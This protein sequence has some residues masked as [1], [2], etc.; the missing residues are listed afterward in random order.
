MCT[1]SVPIRPQFGL[2]VSRK[3][4]LHIGLDKCGSTSIQ[5]FLWMNREQL[6]KA[7]FAVPSLLNWPSHPWLGVLAYQERRDCPVTARMS[8]QLDLEFASD[9]EW[10]GMLRTIHEEFIHW[11]RDQ[12]DGTLLLSAED[13]IARLDESE[14]ANLGGLLRDEVDDI[15]ILVYVR[16]PVSFAVSGWSQRVKSGDTRGML[17]EDSIGGWSRRI[18]AIKYWEKAFPGRVEVRLFDPRAFFAADLV[19]DYR[20]SAGIPRDLQLP[21]PPRTN[22]SLSWP[23]MR[24]LLSI[25]SHFP[26]LTKAGKL[27][28]KRGNLG[29][30]F[31]D[32]LPQSQRYVPTPDELAALREASREAMDWLLYTH[33]SHQEHLWRDVWNPLQDLDIN[34]NPELTDQEAE[35]AHLVTRLWSARTSLLSGSDLARV[36]EKV[37]LMIEGKGLVGLDMAE[38]LLRILNLLEPASRDAERVHEVVQEKLKEGSEPLSLVADVVTERDAARA[39]VESL[40]GTLENLREQLAQQSSRLEALD[41]QRREALRIVSQQQHARQDL[42]DQLA[43]IQQSRSWRWTRFLRSG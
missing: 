13:L 25:N 20:R 26:M 18:N 24:L 40:E 5:R 1:L 37:Q 12:G 7:G 23:A 11:W 35:V 27:N 28:A 9:S 15:R 41:E 31:T 3:V 17:D 43:T 34:R 16:D 32:Y 30:A 14:V 21:S 39:Q 33:L 36:R 22:E 2:N 10:A 8:R 29:E 42:V 6:G 19:Q 4:V 38:D